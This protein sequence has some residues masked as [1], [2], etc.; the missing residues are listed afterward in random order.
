MQIDAVDIN[1][2]PLITLD[3][4]IS[5]RAG[6][7]VASAVQA[8]CGAA[9]RLTGGL[10]VLAKR[11]GLLR[12]VGEAI[13]KLRGAGLWLSEELVQIL[14]AQAGENSPNSALEANLGAALPD[15]PESP[16][17]L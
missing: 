5:Q 8:H 15:R 16:G 3:H 1:A 7:S 14:L 6:R 4:A 10:L 12:S 2:S 9:G 17:G 11:R 13:A